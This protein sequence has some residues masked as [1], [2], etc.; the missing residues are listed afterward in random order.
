MKNKVP[1]VYVEIKLISSVKHTSK[2]PENETGGRGERGNCAQL[3][4]NRYGK[5][6]IRLLQ[7]YNIGS[8]RKCDQY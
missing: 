1:K 7:F 8:F 5:L 3:N 4:S 2:R 6:F